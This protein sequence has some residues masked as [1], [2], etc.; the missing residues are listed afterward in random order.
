M[1]PG[2][3]R[4][5]ITFLHPVKEKNEVGDTVLAERPWKTVWAS[6][7]PLRG[8]E[9]FEARKIQSE[10]THK[11]TIRYLTGITPD[12]K[13]DFKNRI[14]EIEGPPINPEERNRYLEIQATEKV[15][16]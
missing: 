6:V 7:E 3:L 13:I 15:E 9:Y 8:R 4:H 10:A 14:F 11:I 5:R 2:R 16:R 1:N 12:M